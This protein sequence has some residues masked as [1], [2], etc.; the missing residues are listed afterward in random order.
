MALETQALG[1][2]NVMLID[3]DRVR[4]D[5]ESLS[6]IERRTGTP[7]EQRSASWVAERL[8][9]LGASDVHQRPFRTQTTWALA[10][11]THYLS[12]MAAAALGG[13]VGTGLA[14]ATIA[15][16]EADNTG[17][18]QWLRRL[19]P[20]GQGTNVSARL[21]VRGPRRRTLVLVAH[22][23]AAH[24]G[25][26][27]DRRFLEAGRRQALRTGRVTPYNT[28]P[29]VGMLA[30]A[31]P[32]RRARHVGASILG[33]S[34][35]LALQ[36]GRADT[37]PGANDNATGLAV[38]LDLARGLVADPIPGLEVILLVPGGEEASMV[39]M[40]AWMRAEGRGLD[41]LTTLFLG[42]DSLG[43]GEA[44]LAEREGWSARYR[45]DDLAWGDRG[46]A[47]VGLPSPTRFSLGT[48]SDPIIARQAGFTTLSIVSQRDGLL[49]NFHLSSDRADAVDWR[50]VE[51]CAALAGGTIAEWA[52]NPSSSDGNE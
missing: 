27:W 17:R 50:S 45:T 41:R 13:P 34:L 15:S 3:L 46:A 2:A 23:D 51:E 16:Y 30:A 38:L 10:H 11:A 49:G 1:S 36:S 37:V 47:R 7:G 19:L 26:V 20:A 8:Q 24:S 21:P 52:E 18:S 28:I 48:S 44:V 6:A 43:S 14:A 12:G 33:V 32:G 4:A 22:H 25:W 9:E 29:L 35:V 5:V 39:G 40:R 31:L 42:L